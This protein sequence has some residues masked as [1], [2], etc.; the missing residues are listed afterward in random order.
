MAN[1]STLTN[2]FS[3]ALASP[4]VSSDGANA[5]TTGGQL[6][7]NCTS[8][9]PTVYTATADYTL[10]S[11]YLR[12]AQV[13]NVGAGTTSLFLGLN[14][15]D[16]N[17]VQMAWENG[18][19]SARIKNATVYDVFH[20]AAF[21]PVDHAWWDISVVGSDIVWSTS[22]DGLSWST[23]HTEPTSA[24][25]SS[26]SGSLRVAVFS[27]YYGAES[28]PGFTLVD[29]LNTPPAAVAASATIPLLIE[30]EPGGSP[31]TT[32]TQDISSLVLRSRGITLSRGRQDEQS[33]VSA[34][35]ATMTADNS[36]GDFTPTGSGYDMTTRVPVRVRADLGG[37]GLWDLWSGA[38]TSVE[39][40]WSSGVEPLAVLSFSERL[41]RFEQTQLPA[42]LTLATRT[43]PGLR[44]SWPMTDASGAAAAGNPDDPGQGSLATPR[45]RVNGESSD[46]I[47]EMGAGAAPGADEMTCATF[48]AGSPG[49]GSLRLQADASG[50][51]WSTSVSN[52]PLV[53][54]TDRTLAV[55]FRIPDVPAANVVLAFLGELVTIGG[56]WLQVNTSGLLEGRVYDV[57][58]ATSVSLTTTSPV[59]GGRWHLAVLTT[60]VSG[61]SPTRLW[62]DG[63]LVTSTTMSGSAGTRLRGSVVVG[64]TDGVS[65]DFNGQVSHLMVTPMLVD[66]DDVAV[67]WDAGAG[68]LDVAGRTRWVSGA[69][70]STLTASGAA[71]SI[72]LEAQRMA[73]RS[74]M[75]V[76]REA[77]SAARGVVYLAP[78]GDLMLDTIGDRVN[79][80]VDLSVSARDVDPSSHLSFDD[81]GLVNDV[82]ATQPYQ[83][84]SVRREDA[85]SIAY[86]D[87]SSESFDVPI[88]DRATL[89]SWA[90]NHLA[91]FGGPTL[92]WRQIV[93]DVQTKQS[94][95]SVV[96]LLS[97]EVGSLIEVTGLPTDSSPSSTV[98]VFVEG[99][100]HS[101]D[102]DSWTATFNVS[103]A[104]Y[105]T[106]VAVFDSSEFDDGSTFGP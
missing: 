97:L 23:F 89:E 14:V 48:T 67:L 84:G 81:Q 92:R 37:D 94:T 43:L 98:Y 54:P 6:R 10:D 41:A 50:V 74:L 87:R 93:I 101:F 12:V 21:D 96:D 86:R 49:A 68:G 57:A 61:G 105:L 88:R 53:V 62:V 3:A 7:I 80:P 40:S 100:E 11:I 66:D 73:D 104:Y 8:G 75:D 18:G 103:P 70:Y 45:L 26:L 56:I 82:T 19:L 30:I 44:W 38:L 9:Y 58:T 78:D 71:P 15:D 16:D 55:W 33:D 2:D 13:P 83:G 65:S 17:T 29:N 35:T 63:Q 51:P 102:A 72:V 42:A 32:P 47:I 90:L 39:T 25:D 64:G 85:L 76:L 22:P 69:V 106:G 77:A 28:D 24:F 91:L 31:S 1:T 36:G 59:T 79:R 34:G 99:V 52:P 27:G 60:D 20:S 95:V 5:Y 46:G 4:W